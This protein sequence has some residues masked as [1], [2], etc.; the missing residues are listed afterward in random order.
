MH[1][2]RHSLPL[3]SLTALGI[4]KL[5]YPCYLNTSGLTTDRAICISHHSQ[6]IHKALSETST[7]WERTHPDLVLK[8]N[9]NL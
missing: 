9:L 4:F 3:S 6:K 8:D 2:L 1:G 7:A 5:Y